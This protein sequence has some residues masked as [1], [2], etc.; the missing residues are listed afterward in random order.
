[1][2]VNG[3][4]D[5]S[6]LETLVAKGVVNFGFDLRA[7]STNLIPFHKLNQM[8]LNLKD[9]NIFLQFEND[10]ETTVLS[11]LNLLESHQRSFNLL[12]RDA[13]D[14]IYY[15]KLKQ[16][17]YWMFDPAADYQAML[18]LSG[19]KGL[20]L[21]LKW[22]DDY[23]NIPNLWEMIEN[24]GLEVFLHA[25]NFAEIGRVVSLDEVSLSVDLSRE[26]EKAYRSVDQERL[27]KMR[28]LKGTNETTA[29]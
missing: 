23:Q 2:L 18:A 28:I 13:Q 14:P 1:M 24:R 6:T 10:R 19:I 25:D 11:F 29:L 21:P 15:E 8:L 12:F 7:K 26:V 3:I 16:P 17:F 4:Y 5:E 20:F 27:S 9:K 22:L